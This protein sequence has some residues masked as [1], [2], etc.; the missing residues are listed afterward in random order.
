MMRPVRA[1]CGALAILIALGS[2]ATDAAAKEGSK[3]GRLSANQF[4][5]L[6]PFVVPMMPV[7]NER[8]QFTLAVALELQDED[9]RDFVKSRIPVIR[10]RV[11]DMLFRLIAYRT[12]EP[13]VPST[14]LLKKKVHELAVIAVGPDIIESIVVQQVY[15]SRMP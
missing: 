15:Q 10:S 1:F 5:S 7:N 14:A 6:N 9:D 11:Y 4:V 8:K 12:Q 13:L 3:S 2:V